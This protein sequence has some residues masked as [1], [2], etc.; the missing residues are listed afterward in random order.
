[1][2]NQLVNL[3]ERDVQVVS[4]SQ[5]KLVEEVLEEQSSKEVELGDPAMIL[6][7]SGTTGPPKVRLYS[8]ALNNISSDNTVGMGNASSVQ[9]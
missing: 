6:Y 4:F 3:I 1:M 5:E 9:I 7:T 2:L 8:L